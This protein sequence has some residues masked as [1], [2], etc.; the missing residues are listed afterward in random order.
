MAMRIL[1]TN[2]DGRNASGLM[3]LV[4]TLRRYGD[5]FVC[6]PKFE[7]S[8]KS[9][10]IELRRAFEC[11]KEILDN[12]VTLWT[13]DSTPADSVRFAVLGLN[14]K[15]DL[16]IS[17][18]NKGLNMGSDM[19]YSGTVAGASEAVNLGIKAISVST[20]P[21]YYDCAV[22]DLPYVLNHIF[23]E[24][25]LDIHNFYNVNIPQNNKGF[26]FTHHGGPY[27]SDDFVHMGN[28]MYMP[29]AKC[30]FEPSTDKTVDC[31]AVLDGFIS[32]TPLTCNKTDFNILNKLK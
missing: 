29:T 24:G 27:F 23:G 1:V 18:I 10:G 31:D 3:P 14:E 16:V 2:D 6:V 15:F 5:V 32:I 28:D 12:G 25:L 4:E 7:Q 9:H 20:S 30:V 26:K 11:K 19:M 8:G 22:N 13:V 17:G 21:E